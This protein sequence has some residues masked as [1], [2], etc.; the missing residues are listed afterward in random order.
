MPSFGPKG[1]Q[2]KPARREPFDFTVMRDEDPETHNFL[3]LAITD[4]PGLAAAFTNVD[5]HPDR[6]IGGL[7]RVISRMLDNKDGVPA[8]WR[9]E[10]LP[11]KDDAGPDDPINFRAPDGSILPMEQAAQFEAVEAGS[12]RRRWLH[13]MEDDDSVYVEK[14]DLLAL[15][16]WLVSLAG[17]GP[18]ANAG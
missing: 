13:L 10:P 9:A 15:F 17:K 2:T 3:A 12:S 5:K 6:A 1:K 16:R 18:T 8:Q 11:E 7:F 4:L 14:E